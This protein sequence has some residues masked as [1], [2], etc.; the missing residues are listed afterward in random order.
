MSSLTG[1]SSTLQLHYANVHSLRYFDKTFI[2][3]FFNKSCISHIFL[4]HCSSVLVVIKTIMHHKAKKKNINAKKNRKKKILKTYLVRS[5]M[6][7]EAE[8]L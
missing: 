8:T 3:M 4:V 2:E 6:L 7:F 1:I 5:H